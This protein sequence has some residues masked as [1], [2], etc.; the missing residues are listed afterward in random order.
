LP[1][2]QDL[3]PLLMALVAAKQATALVTLG[4]QWMLKPQVYQMLGQ[5]LLVQLD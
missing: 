4:S 1:H 5:G 3:L 2:P